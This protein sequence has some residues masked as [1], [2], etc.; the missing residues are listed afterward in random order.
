MSVQRKILVACLG[1][2]AIILL[3]G[4]LAHQQALKWSRLVIGI[5][6]HAF[7]GM[8]YVDQT[9]EEFL[10]LLAADV[11]AASRFLRK[12]VELTC[13]K[14]WNGLTSHWNAPVRITPVPLVCN[15]RRC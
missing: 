7:I 14:S 10:R 11:M 8:S 3:L 12:S 15:Y 2:V 4:G 6:D 13:R 5:Y 1:F 9:Q